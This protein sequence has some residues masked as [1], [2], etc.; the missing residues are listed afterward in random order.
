MFGAIGDQRGSGDAD[1]IVAG[2]VAPLTWCRG[3]VVNNSFIAVRGLHVGQLSEH[4]T[5]S[6]IS[7]G[8]CF[9]TTHGVLLGRF[10]FLQNAPQVIHPLLSS[11]HIG[12]SIDKFMVAVNNQCKLAVFSWV[13]AGILLQ[14]HVR[15]LGKKVGH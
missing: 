13:T 7:G 6:F 10:V 12:C 2:H 14:L 8:P 15:G 3:G 5:A 11:G 4:C 1:G 9:G